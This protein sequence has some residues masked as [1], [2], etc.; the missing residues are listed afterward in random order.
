[1]VIGVREGM[2]ELKERSLTYFDILL[3]I[4]VFA[5][6]CVCLRLCVCVCEQPDI[7]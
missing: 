5:C 6:V 2:E 3:L 4:C 7:D 1:M